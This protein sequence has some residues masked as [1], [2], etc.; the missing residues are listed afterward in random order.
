MV[1]PA[2]RAA[3][4]AP[5]RPLPRGAAEVAA[6][7]RNHLGWT[8]HVVDAGVHLVLT[9]GLVAFE[10]PAHQAPAVLAR[11]TGLGAA[12]PALRTGTDRVA[13]LCDVNDA[14]FTQADMP[15]GIRHLRAPTSLPLP[16]PRPSYAWFV[17]PDPDHR[18][19]PS[20]TA[21]LHAVRGAVAA[22]ARAVA[23]QEVPV[24]RLWQV[25]ARK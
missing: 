5:V 15:V 7:Y 24:H 25:R 12:G 10:V 9:A 8:V 20:A 13:F 21:V 14:V 23:H 3:P 17:A 18:W 2:H 22:A 6:W 19:L 1:T 4:T 16:S 11:L